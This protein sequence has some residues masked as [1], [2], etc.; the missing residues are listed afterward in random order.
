M[1][2]AITLFFV[3]VGML[4][5]AT[6]LSNLKQKATALQQDNA[7]L[8]ASKIANSPEFSCGNSF[9]TGMSSCVDIDKVMAL[10][11]KIGDYKNGNF[12]GITGLEIRKIYPKNQGR[13][14]TKDNFPNCGKIT[15]IQSNKGTGISNFVSWCEFDS[16]GGNPY[17]RCYLGKII[18]TYTGVS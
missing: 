8:L 11:S 17:P 3:L 12:W 4:I 9:G 6:N 15:L 13:E 16:N 1:I 2:L 10:K 18:I 7:R 5:L 14:C